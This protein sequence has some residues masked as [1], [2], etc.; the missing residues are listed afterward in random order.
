VNTV[1]L[2]II[3]LLGVAV[4]NAFGITKAYEKFSYGTLGLNGQTGGGGWNQGWLASNVETSNTNL[5]APD[6]YGYTPL[7]GMV[8]A[9]MAGRIARRRF[10]FNIDMNSPAT[11]YFSMLFQKNDSSNGTSGEWFHLIRLE[12]ISANIICKFGVGSDESVFV[13]PFNN[14]E[15]TFSS[16]A[17]VVNIGQPY[18]AIA[19]LVVNSGKNDVMYFKVYDVGTAYFPGDLTEENSDAYVALD[20]NDIITHFAF[21][22]GSTQDSVCYDE[23]RIG[24][25]FYDVVNT[26]PVNHFAYEN[27]D[28][29]GAALYGQTGGTGF[30]DAW[31]G[32]SVT[33]STSSLSAPTGYGFAPTGGRL[34]TTSTGFTV[35]R[36]LAFDIKLNP[37]GRDPLVYYFSA[38]FRKNDTT[39]IGTGEYLMPIRLLDS[40]DG[41]VADYLIGSTENVGTN[42]GGGA[43]GLSANDFVEFGQTYLLV[44]KLLC[45]GANTPQYKDS[46]DW[47]FVKVY[48]VGTDT[49][50]NRPVYD[51]YWDASAYGNS[52]AI[53]KKL[54]INSGS[55]QDR[56]YV[57]EIRIGTK[58]EEVVNTERFGPEPISD[59][60]RDTYLKIDESEATRLDTA[61]TR[62]LMEIKPVILPEGEN[63]V[64]S[65]FHMGWPV[66]SQSGDNIVMVSRTQIYHSAC[67]ECNAIYPEGAD[68]YSEGFMCYSSDS[69]RTWGQ[70]IRTNLFF[71]NSEGQ[72]TGGMSNVGTTDDGDIFV[73]WK[74]IIKS[75]DGGKSWALYEDAFSGLP[76]DSG[77][78]GPNISH[79]AAF[80]LLMCNGT[81]AIPSGTY[82]P[83]WHTYIK[84]SLDNGIT[85]QSMAWDT[86]NGGQDPNYY[87]MP[88]EP[89]NVSWGPGHILLLSREHNETM[90]SD[91]N[92]WAMSQH[93]Y[94][95]IDGD[96]FSDIIMTTQRTNIEGN[97]QADELANDTADLCY[98]PI[99]KRIEALQSSR[100]AGGPGFD[101]NGELVLMSSLNLWSIDPNDL[102]AGSN[103][104]RFEGTLLLRNNYWSPTNNIDGLHPGGATIDVNNNVQ[105][106]FVY[107]GGKGCEKS[108]VFQFDRTL[109]TGQLSA[110]L[111]STVPNHL[112]TKRININCDDLADDLYDS[113]I[114]VKL[115]SSIITHSQ[116]NP[117]ANDLYFTDDQQRILPHRILKWATTASSYVLVQVPH[118]DPSINTNHIF[119]HW[120]EPNACFHQHDNDTSPKLESFS[121]SFWVQNATSTGSYYMVWKGNN[122]RSDVAG[123]S[124]FRDTSANS[125]TLRFRLQGNYNANMASFTNTTSWHHVVGVIDRS[126]NQSRLYVDGALIDTKNIAAV[127]SIETT[128]A[129]QMEASSYG[130][131][132]D[133]SIVKHA[134]TASEIAD[135]YSAGRTT[136]TDLSYSALPMVGV[137]ATDNSATEYPGNT[138]KYR[139]TRNTSLAEPLYV[140]YY[141]SGTAANATDYNN[142]SGTA[143]IPAGSTYVD[144]T[145]A[146]KCDVMTESTETAV[147]N[148]IDGVDY[149]LDS[150]TSATVNITNSDCTGYYLDEVQVPAGDGIVNMIDFALFADA[151]M[152]SDTSL[153]YNVS[154]DISPTGGDG[155]ID[156]ADLNVFI[157]HWLESF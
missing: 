113:F 37:S 157:Q 96:N 5:S 40:G 115:T 145:L 23:L 62:G 1:K 84:R 120:G 140:H 92:T 69:G 76:T 137:S 87:T 55:S 20:S 6:A 138:G 132:D 151:W 66:A 15:R 153:N 29:D 105:H 152:S 127:T 60:L 88:A 78:M 90:A 3:V 149:D 104:W 139:I 18:L 8:N 80:G 14:S 130:A 144:V 47:S 136:Y 32:T 112:Y 133:I 46:N 24:T 99:T 52:N 71:E 43:T 123:W 85:W 77:F 7:P 21:D 67:A 19:K 54:R 97:L 95:Y 28:Y 57:D 10:G 156:S 31:T 61:A 116:F 64:G 82:S 2:F 147:L 134:M 146:P 114:T 100:R 73:K 25:T 33:T 150:T 9:N 12:D 103:L 125:N 72:T 122:P 154:Y 98:N 70:R 128:A 89:A 4:G 13:Q 59:Y 135:I 111:K 41:I 101:G 34:D 45:R 63:F 16:D 108:G 121:V 126:A 36:N 143:I 30:S 48:K 129:V 93:V 106:I 117:D 142:M 38:L 118:L 65:N 110:Y 50:Y 131:V 119:M 39:D 94:E 79:N 91:G 81:N 35:T 155:W 17:G 22:W 42:V 11:Y 141:M 83:P 68:D 49:V 51:S 102:L 56:V 58:W 53:I 27:F 75:S 124:F 148:I 109:N 74:G 107:A 44:G 26:N 86:T